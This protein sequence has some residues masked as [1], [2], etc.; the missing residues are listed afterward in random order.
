MVEHA[1]VFESIFKPEV[2]KEGDHRWFMP[3]RKHLA[4]Y[5][6]GFEGAVEM[7][8]RLMLT[9]GVAEVIRIA[10]ES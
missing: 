10:E 3:M 6:K 9:N 5:C 8:S 2:E 4:W 1:K 7:R